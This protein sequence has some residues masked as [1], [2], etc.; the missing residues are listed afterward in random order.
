MALRIA[1]RVRLYIGAL[2]LLQ[3]VERKM[4][5]HIGRELKISR[6]LR[7]RPVFFDWEK[8]EGG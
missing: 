2:L 5:Y 6:W 3:G 4:A 8:T 1:L 7:D